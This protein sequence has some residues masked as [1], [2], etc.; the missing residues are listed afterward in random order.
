MWRYQ[1][2]RLKKHLIFVRNDR[3]KRDHEIFLNHCT[4]RINPVVRCW[5]CHGNRRQNEFQAKDEENTEAGFLQDKKGSTLA[6]KNYLVPQTERYSFGLIQR[7]E[8]HHSVYLR[9]K[10]VSGCFWFNCLEQQD[11]LTII[12]GTSENMA[13]S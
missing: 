8:T 12:Y 3:F 11:H 13:S 9:V 5:S 2:A 7:L 1:R 6:A 10:W 4:W